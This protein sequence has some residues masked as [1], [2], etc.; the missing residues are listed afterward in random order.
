MTLASSALIKFLLGT[1]SD[2]RRLYKAKCHSM[3]VVHL[4]D[5]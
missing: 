1:R 5:A 2:P 3:T 4:L